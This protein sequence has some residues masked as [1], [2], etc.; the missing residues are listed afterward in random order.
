MSGKKVVEEGRAD[1]LVP[2]R[3]YRVRGGS[4]GYWV[5]RITGPTGAE[6]REMGFVWLSAVFADAGRY[7]EGPM[8]A[9]LIVFAVRKSDA[10]MAGAE[11]T[12][13][14][15]DESLG[16]EAIERAYAGAAKTVLIEGW[17]ELGVRL[18]EGYKER[19][20]GQV[21]LEPGVGEWRRRAE[22][23]RLRIQGLPEIYDGR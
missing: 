18:V 19:R 1:G 20:V 16:D 3:G 14:M 9:D 7:R 2:A 21:L 10:E 5:S 23:A 6:Y 4:A 22:Q 13:A 17:T 11:L 12:A 15:E 8:G